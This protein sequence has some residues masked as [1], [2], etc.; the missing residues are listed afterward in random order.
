[1]T[2]NPILDRWRLS[3]LVACAGMLAI[4][5][6]FQTFG[7]L[8]PCE[9]CLKQRDVYWAT[10]AVALA[11][12]LWVRAPG[13]ARFRQLTC[14]ILAIGFLGEAAVA[15]YHAG[16]EWKFWP[17]PAS[18]TGA[19]GGVTAADLARLLNGGPARPPA[20]DKP[21]W[22]FAGVSMA[23]WNALAALG[24]TALSI[25]AAMRERSKP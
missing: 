25:A 10:G 11:C 3:A 13:G 12:M 24:L 6:A 2:L 23:G 9:L 14:W 17:G 8:A 19:A 16:V 4:A 1:M 15:A 22:V 18:C 21:A 20:C 7:G 5:H